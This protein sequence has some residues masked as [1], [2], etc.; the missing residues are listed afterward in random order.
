VRDTPNG[1]SAV[2]LIPALGGVERKLAEVFMRLNPKLCWTPDGRQLIV[3]GRDNPQF[4]NGLF[5]LTV[6]T[7]G[8]HRLTT[9]PITTIGGDASPAISPDGKTLAFVRGP[10]GA[11]MD[12]FALSLSADFEPAGEPRQ[13][14]F[15][16][17]RSPAQAWAPDGRDIIFISEVQGRAGLWR[18]AADGSGRPQPLAGVGEGSSTLAISPGAHRLVYSCR[19]QDQN[20]W[21][22]EVAGGLAQPATRIIAS[23]LRDFEPRYAPDGRK[24]SYASD[25]S[26]HIEVWTADADGSNQV[27][28][29]DLKSSDLWR[30]LVAG[31]PADRVPVGGCGPAGAVHDPGKRRPGDATDEQPGPRYGAELFPRRPRRRKAWA[32]RSMT[33]RPR[34]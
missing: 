4:A 6:A 15:D 25:R 3:S 18:V 20:V 33:R 22:I 21:R 31:W 19:L 10:S 14:T 29:T 2:M 17:R 11:S 30:A 7:G 12:L 23:T 32:K 24:I 26:G 9:P 34:A 5:L 1:R 27:Q 13:I 16:K 8:K 28:L